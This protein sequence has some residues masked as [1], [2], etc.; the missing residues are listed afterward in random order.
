MRVDRPDFNAAAS[1]ASLSVEQRE[2]LWAALGRASRGTSGFSFV[3]VTAYLGALIILCTMG[4]FGF[5]SWQSFDGLGILALALSYAL[6]FVAAGHLLWFQAGLKVQGGLLVT[7]AVCMVPLALYGLEKAW[8]WEVDRAFVPGRTGFAWVKQSGLL[9][10]TGTILAALA[11]I[12]WLRFS[13]LALPIAF[14][15]WL[16]TQ[17]LATYGQ[18]EG[19]SFLQAQMKVSML[20]GLGLLAVGFVVDRLAKEDFAFWLYL[21][22]LL[23]MAYT[24][25]VQPGDSELRHALYCLLALVSLGIGAL[26]RRRTFLVF[27]ALGVIGYLGHLSGLFRP[28]LVYPLIASLVGGLVLFLGVQLHR[29]QAAVETFLEALFPRSVRRLLPPRRQ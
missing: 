27:G 21:T 1:E 24:V 28:S 25:A 20:F 2:R 13:L 9:I 8:G 10:H 22:A 15:L 5:S 19:P 17:E 18:P 29:R 11:A 16:L 14:A 7:L 3:N 12:R 6:C 26:L 4:L 23:A